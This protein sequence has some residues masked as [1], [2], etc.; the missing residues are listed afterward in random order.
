MEVQQVLGDVADPDKPVELR[1]GAGSFPPKPHLVDDLCFVVDLPVVRLFDQ[2]PL[3]TVYDVLVHGHQASNDTG[4]KLIPSS[5]AFKL[6]AVPC[7]CDVQVRFFGTC[8]GNMS[9]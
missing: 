7:R 4:N 2:V 3:K 9:R 6:C 5:D 8:Q 1:V